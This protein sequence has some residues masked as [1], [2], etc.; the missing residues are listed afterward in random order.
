MEDKKDFDFNKIIDNFI[1]GAKHVTDTLAVKGGE[2]VKDS[3]LKDL[4]DYYPFYSWPPLNLY[5][6]E[7]NSLIF[8]FGL[9][10]F[11]KDDIQIE[12]DGDYMLFSATLSN[13]YSTG[14]VV[15]SYKKKL[16][17]GDIKTQKYFVPEIRFDRKNYTMHMKN[18]LLRV[19]L[20]FKE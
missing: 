5:N 20:P 1:D 8:E 19:V 13:I 2:F 17:L 3:G 15:R 7:D 14:D 9:P 10:G 6:S 11:I 4:K 12:F 16:K 18:G